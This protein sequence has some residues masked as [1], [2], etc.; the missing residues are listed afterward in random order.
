[1]K[2]CHAAVHAE[3]CVHEHVLYGGGFFIPAGTGGDGR[4]NVWARTF[5]SMFRA[6]SKSV[7]RGLRLLIKDTFFCTA[8]W[9]WHAEATLSQNGTFTPSALGRDR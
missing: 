4:R 2:L 5:C 7:N 3:D 8:G 1:M 6:S 9:H